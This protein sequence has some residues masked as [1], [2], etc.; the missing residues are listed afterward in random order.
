MGH[1]RLVDKIYHSNELPKRAREA[2]RSGKITEAKGARREAEDEDEY[3]RSQD[4]ACRIRPASGG[5]VV[6]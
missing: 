6:G 1:K 3:L 5:G 2:R 4:A